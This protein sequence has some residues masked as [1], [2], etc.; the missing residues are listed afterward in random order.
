M[1]KFKQL[2]IYMLTAAI[3]ISGCKKI[4]RFPESEFSDADFWNTETDLI[5]AANRL[6]QQLD[7]D[8]IDN[9]ADDAVNQG[10]PNEISTGNR[11]IPNTSADWNDRYDEIF[12]ANNILQKAGK[13]KVTDAIKNRYF[14]EARFF[15]AYAYFKLLRIYGDVP[16]VLQTLTLNSPDLYMARTPRAQVIQ[17][18]Y[19]DL[20]FAAQWLPKRA[21][22]PA[23]QYGRV[24]KSSAWALKAR[25]ALY[26]GTRAKFHNVTSINWQNHLTTAIA[27]AQNVMGEGHVLY[28]NYGNL[29]NATG[30]GPANT[31]NI[32]VKIYGVSNTNLILGHNNSRDL[33]NGRMAPTRNLLRQY[34]YSDGLPAFNV[35]NTPSTTVSTFFVAEGSEASYNTILDNRDPR[36]AFTFFRAGDVAYQG[37]WVPKTSLGSR[38]AYAPKKGFSVADQ[39]INGAGTTDRLLIRYAE[40]LLIYAEAKF[41]LNGSISDAD[42]NLSINALRTRVGFAPKL[43]N[44]FVTTNNLSM[45]DEIRRERT[46][47]LALEGFRYDDLIRWKLAEILL[48]EELLGAKF[49]ASEWVGTNGNSLNLNAN[50]VLI[51]EAGT[52]RH[53]RADRDYLY[54]VPIHEITTSG[55]TVVQNPNWQ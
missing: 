1:K 14:G 39:T 19:D 49:I 2:S 13:A 35:D 55:G 28:A 32:L 38:T 23:A 40:V 11:S 33:E 27:A 44:A 10:G 17:S 46:V 24:T 53:F 5:N 45:R 54:P 48:P 51:T 12:T 42:L 37:P 9:R 43:T 36:V 47:E 16:L 15:R 6:Y 50:N 34:L 3:V 20:D 26:E 31:E 25:A 18:I 30:E 8:W 22:L 52:N 29:F 41:E 21:D 7:A 4:D